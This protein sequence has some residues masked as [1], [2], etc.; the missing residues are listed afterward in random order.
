MSFH[1]VLVTYISKHPLNKFVSRI[2]GPPGQSGPPGAVGERGA[3]G[4]S[5][6]Q[7][8]DGQPVTAKQ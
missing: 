1:R 2:Q 4:D 7:G 6:P 3:K 5:G 8:V